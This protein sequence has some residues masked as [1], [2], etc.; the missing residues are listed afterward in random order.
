MA[1]HGF[2][3]SRHDGLGVQGPQGFQGGGPLGQVRVSGVHTGLVFHQVT[4]EQ[5]FFGLHPR[6]GVATG[7]ASTWVPNLDFDA[8]QVDGQTAL[9]TGLA[10]TNDHGRPSEA[11]HAVCTSEQAGETVHLALHVFGTTFD[12]QVAGAFAGDDFSGTFGKVGAGPQHPHRVVVGEQH[13]FDRLVTHAADL[14]N[15]VLC[16]QGRGG[17]VTHQNEFVAN[18]HARVGV[19]FSRVSPAVGAELG[20]ADVFIAQVV[21]TGEGLGL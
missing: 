16:H 14:G 11:R 12:D 15:Q 8:T 21:L 4:A 9:T 13:V 3:A 19:A 17:G 6:D 7:V 5:D 2:A 20:E 10:V 1:L 18:D